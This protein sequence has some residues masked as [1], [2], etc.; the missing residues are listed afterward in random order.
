MHHTARS[1][2][3]QFLRAGAA[4]QRVRA[5]SRATQTHHATFQAMQRK[6]ERSAGSCIS[7]A[8]HLMR[9]IDILP[10]R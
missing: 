8:T 10:S 4:T 1:H 2:G 9:T 6:R 5:L 7:L 3:Q